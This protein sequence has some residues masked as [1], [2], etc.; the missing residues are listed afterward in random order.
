MVER[1]ILWRR[2]FTIEWVYKLITNFKL[3]VTNI[4][5]SC[6]RG[7]F[8]CIKKAA[9]RNRDGLAVTITVNLRVF[10]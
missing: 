4:I 8:F 6:P 3:R 5:R 2:R 1:E 10:P 9:T 7:Q